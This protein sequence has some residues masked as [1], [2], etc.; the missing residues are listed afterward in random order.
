[1][2]KHLESKI[3]S[4]ALQT[5]AIAC[6]Y[7]QFVTWSDEFWISICIS[8]INRGALNITSALLYKMAIRS[9]KV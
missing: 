2:N 3:A 4:S 5:F 9:R 6:Y 1:M 7:V 8:R